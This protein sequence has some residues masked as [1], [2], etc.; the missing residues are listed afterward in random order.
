MTPK[1]AYFK[2]LSEKLESNYKTMGYDFS[3]FETKEAAKDFIISNVDK[4]ASIGFGGSMSLN[5]VGIIDYFR[6]NNYKNLIDRDAAKDTEEKHAMHVKCFSGDVFF[7]STNA[8][9][10]DGVLIN[11]D[12]TGNRVAPM[13]YGPKKVY[14]V[15]GINKLE[16]NK[17][18]GSDRARNKASV[19]NNIRFGTSNACTKT[20]QCMECKAESTL[21]VYTS[22]IRG[23][24]PKGRLHIIFINDTLGF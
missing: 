11:I 5:E 1:E 17:A 13:I 21:C 14:V 12:K 3:S 9:T 22:F 6:A 4:D 16:F 8:M 7:T 23:S 19:M 10:M 2:G 24:F 18:D 15:A 20:L